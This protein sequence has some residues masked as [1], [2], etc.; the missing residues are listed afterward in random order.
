[1]RLFVRESL[2]DKVNEI[3]IFTKARFYLN[4]LTQNFGT[5]YPYS[6]LDLVFIPDLKNNSM[7]HPGGITIDDNFIQRSLNPLEFNQFN[8]ILAQGM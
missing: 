5:N 6:K 1:M 3:E 4:Y 8:L 2:S 7:E